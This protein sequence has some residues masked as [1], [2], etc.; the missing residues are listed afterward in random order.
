MIDRLHPLIGSAGLSAAIY[1]QTTDVEVEVNG[2][3][4]YDRALIKMD[5]DR[6][7]AANRKLY[8]PSPPPPVI[9]QVA[10]ASQAKGIEWR[11]TT[12]QPQDN[13]FAPEFDDAS[14]QK[15]LG[16]FGTSGTPG[17][18]VR[19]EWSTSD[20]W[21]RRPF[22]LPADTKLHDP[23]FWLHHDEDADV[24]LNGK[25]VLK[26]SGYTTQYERLPMDKQ[27]RAAFKPGKNVLAVHCHQTGGGQYIDVGL[28]E[29]EPGR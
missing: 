16:G 26:A 8:T 4:T 18:V 1:T 5:A 27:A 19:T 23:Q 28:V 15:G 17:A 3:L 22:D 13:W 20:I 9:K 10:M 24:Y 21:M 12:E 7:T 6:V 14:W 2:L 11:Y 29:I 25:L